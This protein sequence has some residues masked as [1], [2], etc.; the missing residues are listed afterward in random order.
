MN[1]L[2]VTAHMG[3][4]VGAILSGISSNDKNN[5]HKILCIEKTENMHFYNIATEAKVAIYTL[6]YCNI[7]PI[8]EWA[9]IVQVEWWHHPKVMQFM[10]EVL[11]VHRI[12][13]IMWSHI[14]GCTYPRLPASLMYKIDRLVFTSPRSYYNPSFT[15]DD[16]VYAK[17]NCP[18]I[19][20]VAS[21]F[22]FPIRH[23]SHPQF[24]VAYVGFLGYTQ[25]NSDFLSYCS[26]VA[27][28]PSIQFNICGDTAY[29]TDLLRDI[30]DS[31]ISQLFNIRGYCCDVP[32]ELEKM[33]VFG[34][35]LDKKHTGTTENA[36]LEAMAAGVV[37]VALN[38]GC[39]K[40]I[41]KNG[42]TG[43]L[44]DDIAG[45]REVIEF[46]YHNPQERSNMAF[47]AAEDIRK[48][49]SLSS[50]ILKWNDVY[51][52]LLSIPKSYHRNYLHDVFGRTP[53]DWFCSCY[54][55]DF[56]HMSGLVLSETKASLPQYLRY[57]PEDK[58]LLEFL[59]WNTTES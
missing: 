29:G 57:F 4:G 59:S 19:P 42:V 16:T 30:K 48:S 13:L 58:Q 2:H 11:S 10:I 39:E 37:P 5:C 38:Q 56:Y 51:Q 26:A 31:S 6:D 3:G 44:V 17:H 15:S 8:I 25:L 28:I 14:S 33:D 9:D 53:S 34:Y 7:E 54:E 45:Y 41:I 46:L 43:F 12:R 55:G 52:Q 49:Y 24:I 1:I 18:V 40:Y 35:L 22:S 32:H 27:H 47:A 20:S 21:D 50:T 36:L 23:T